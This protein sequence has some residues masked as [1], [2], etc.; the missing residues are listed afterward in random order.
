MAVCP[1]VVG[2]LPP[3]FLGGQTAA[4]NRERSSVKGTPLRRSRGISMKR[5][6]V[7]AA[8]ARASLSFTQL[9]PGC[10][11]LGKPYLLR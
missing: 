5:G 7:R 3:I 6:L 9:G 10:C 8:I 1:E 4:R 11:V 2:L